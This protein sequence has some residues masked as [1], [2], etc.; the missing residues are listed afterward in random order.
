MT[1]TLIFTQKYSH[2]ISDFDF[3]INSGCGYIRLSN[4]FSV[5][6]AWFQVS[7]ATKGFQK[8]TISFLKM[9]FSPIF[10]TTA[11]L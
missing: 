7:A 6:L 5:F 8:F 2:F 11:I 1:K 10:N 4:H 9:K 3:I